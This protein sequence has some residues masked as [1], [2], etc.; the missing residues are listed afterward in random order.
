LLRTYGIDLLDVYTGRM[1]LRRLRVLIEGLGVDTK[2]ARRRGGWEEIYDDWT[3]SGLLL[4][5]L[6]EAQ[7]EDGEEVIPRSK[8]PKAIAERPAAREIPVVSLSEAMG[9]VDMPDHEFG[10]TYGE[11][12]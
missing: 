5:R 6:L 3:T 4:G 8:A 2:T 7:S 12:D 11:G 9:F 1:S 10:A